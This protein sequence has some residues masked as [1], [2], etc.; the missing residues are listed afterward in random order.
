MEQHLAL[1]ILV[2]TLAGGALA[3]FGL[4]RWR[5]RQRS[6]AVRGW[7]GA[8][9]L[10]RFGH[11]PEGVRVNCSYDKN[12]PVLVGF[13]DAGLR[14]RMRFHCPGGAA[15]LQLESEQTERR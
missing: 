2:G 10:D 8:Y 5:C 12:W 9:L 11:S 1:M 15:S 14:H 7:V 6:R 3:G 4:Y 13:D